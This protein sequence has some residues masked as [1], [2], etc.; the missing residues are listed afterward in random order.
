MVCEVTVTGD[1]VIVCVLVSASA[2]MVWVTDVKG[3][4]RVI[5]TVAWIFSLC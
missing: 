4:E 3:V 1:G 5:V 2:V